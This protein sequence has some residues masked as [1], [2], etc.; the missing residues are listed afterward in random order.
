M[1]LPTIPCHRQA[2]PSISCVVPAYNEAAHLSAF[3]NDLRRTLAAISSS[4]EIIVVN[5]GSTDA[6]EEAMRP[7]LT[8][9][10]I[11]YL[12][13]AR[14][15]GKEAA[16]TA[17][18]ENARGEAV[19]LMDADY[20]H[21]LEL[22][23][24]MV[25]LWR[26]GYD[27]IYGV[28]ADRSA[29]HLLKRWGTGFFYSLLEAGSSIRIPRNAGDFRLFDRKV[30]DALRKLPESNR[31]MKGLYA[32]VGFNTVALPF[33]PAARATSTSSFGLRSLGRLALSGVTAFT[34]WPLRVWSAIGVA[35]SVISIF[36]CCYITLDSLIFGNDVPG[37]STL[38]AGLIFFSGVQLVSIGIL[39]EY[40]GRVY[41]EVKRRPLYLLAH[42]ID[43]GMAGAETIAPA[44]EYGV[45]SAGTDAMPANAADQYAAP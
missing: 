2:K 28:I 45:A 17:G 7:H 44:T 22:L 9:P 8:Q 26:D 36:Y 38:A 30:A 6:T 10:G 25:R 32:W 23:P 35:I 14:N 41:D 5:D 40:I 1:L 29:E 43:N 31:F 16:L 18:I 37:W 19:I 13:L 27:M 12:G 3:L 20:Q 42:D 11:R 39:G 15:F 34:T 33:V 4:Y 21:P 24:E